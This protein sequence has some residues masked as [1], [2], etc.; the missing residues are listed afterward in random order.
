MIDNLNIID[1]LLRIIYPKIYPLKKRDKNFL[2]SNLI[3]K[4]QK[5]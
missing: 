2:I 4:T 5:L 3:Y 1:S